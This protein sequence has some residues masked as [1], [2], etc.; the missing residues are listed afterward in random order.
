MLEY[1][2]IIGVS[3]DGIPN[4]IINGLFLHKE[5]EVRKIPVGHI[6]A[7]TGN[8]FSTNWNKFYNKDAG[9]NDSLYLLCKEKSR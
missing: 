9:I 5:V 4:E 1:D 3:G 2:V 6:P 8:G 7:G